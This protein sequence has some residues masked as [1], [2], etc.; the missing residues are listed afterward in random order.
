MIRLLYSKVYVFTSDGDFG[1]EN[2]ES[3][4]AVLNVI[5][6]VNVEIQTG[7]E[8]SSFWSSRSS[9]SFPTFSVSF[10]SDRME[11]RFFLER[12]FADQD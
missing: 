4:D 3:Q 12:A 10:S 1:T 9:A 2:F 7:L 8:R 11:V 5:C 6:L